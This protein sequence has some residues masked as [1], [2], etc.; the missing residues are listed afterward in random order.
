MIEY[1][2]SLEGVTPAMLEGFFDGWPNPPSPRTHLRILEGSRYVVL[3]LED[4]R[5]V[6][7]VNAV[8]D[9]VFYAY[10]PLLEVLPSHRNRGIGPELTRRMLERLRGMYAVDLLCDPALQPFYERLG[11]M[12]AS[13]MLVRR[14]EHQSGE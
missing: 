12:R 10:I 11:M 5:V 13:G 14:F 6:G 7:F 8:G 3:A 9:G 1:R 2:D 4:E